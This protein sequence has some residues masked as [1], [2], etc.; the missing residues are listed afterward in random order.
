MRE[1]NQDKVY[2]CA[3]IK[4]AISHAIKDGIINVAEDFG[5]QEEL[6]ECIQ[7]AEEKGNYRDYWCDK[8]NNT[9]FRFQIEQN[10]DTIYIDLGYR[11]N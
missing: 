2:N 6:N 11:I 1:K 10:D 3:K 7:V 9:Y 5:S 8:E 4:T